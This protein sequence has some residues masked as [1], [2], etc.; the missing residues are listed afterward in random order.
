MLWALTYYPFRSLRGQYV[1]SHYARELLLSAFVT[2][3]CLKYLSLYVI[4]SDLKM[5]ANV[6]CLNL[7][8]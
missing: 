5:R 2:I 7:I 4:I 6:N 8:G 1:C 3:W